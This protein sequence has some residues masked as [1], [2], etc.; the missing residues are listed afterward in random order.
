MSTTEPT[1]VY[2]LESIHIVQKKV[3]S[4]FIRKLNTLDFSF[5]SHIHLIQI[6]GVKLLV[7]YLKLKHKKMKERD[8]LGR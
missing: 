7:R 5:L 3:F 2:K 1:E 4:Y 8:L 6:L